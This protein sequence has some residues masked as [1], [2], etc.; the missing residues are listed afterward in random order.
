MSLEEQHEPLAV[1]SST[2]AIWQNSMTPQ[3]TQLLQSTFRLLSWCVSTDC[4]VYSLFCSI[5]ITFSP[6]YFFS[7]DAEKN[8]KVFPA[9]EQNLF[10]LCKEY[11]YGLCFHKTNDTLLKQLSLKVVYA[12]SKQEKIVKC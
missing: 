4:R 2:D 7:R 12:R 9:K 5:T 10:P 1:T 11:M 3:H 8:P 6:S